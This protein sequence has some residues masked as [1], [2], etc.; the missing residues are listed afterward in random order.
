MTNPGSGP[1]GPCAAHLTCSRADWAV[2]L[3]QSSTV[4]HRPGGPP[5]TR[6]RS[7]ES[8]RL[9][10]KQTRSHSGCRRRLP[11]SGIVNRSTYSVRT[12]TSRYTTCYGTVPPCSA[13][14]EYVPFT[15]STYQYILFTPSTYRVRSTSQK[16]MYLV[17]TEYRI[18]DKSTYLRLK[19]QTF[20]VAYQ[21]VPV[22]TEYIL[23]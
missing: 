6:T 7:G 23:F 18:H 15:P 21:Y 5:A 13:L 14:F 11:A 8:L 1:A 20:R 16:R 12:G 3:S 22:R 4:N 9:E 2:H 10:A 17:R 19:V